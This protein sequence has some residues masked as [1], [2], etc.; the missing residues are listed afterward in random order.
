MAELQALVVSQT[1][2]PTGILAV[3]TIKND[4]NSNLVQCTE[5]DRMVLPGRRHYKDCGWHPSG[6]ICW[7]YKP[8]QAPDSWQFKEAYIAKKKAIAQKTTQKSTTTPLHQ[9]T[10]N[11]NPTT[12]K[13]VMFS[14]N[15]TTAALLDDRK[16]VDQW[17]GG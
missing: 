14:T 15:Y 4:N 2:E 12:K 7:S 8:E 5:C 13:T 3:T 9:Q 11:A 16:A 10:S 6:P 1:Y 17:G